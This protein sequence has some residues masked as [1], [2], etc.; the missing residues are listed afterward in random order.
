MEAERHAAFHA[1][2]MFNCANP[3]ELTSLGLPYF[4]VF[5]KALELEVQIVNDGGARAFEVESNEP[6]LKF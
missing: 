1:E 4:Q 6:V 2:Y 5:P 3:A